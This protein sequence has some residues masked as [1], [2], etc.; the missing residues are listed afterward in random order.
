MARYPGQQPRRWPLVIVGGAVVMLAGLGTGWALSG[1]AS[2]SPTTTSA[3]ACPGG[4]DDAGR[5]A[6]AVCLV[7]SYFALENSSPGERDAK[8]AGLVLPGALDSARTSYKALDAK[9][10]TE[11]AA[12]AAT[13]LTASGTSA[14]SGQAWVAFVDSYRDGSAPLAQW[15]IT[16]F[17][18]RWQGGRW[19]LDGGV[20]TQVDATPQTAGTAPR[21]GFG[22]GW[23]AA[24][25]G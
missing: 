20:A 6:A 1:R 19:W 12:V 13:N 18:L 21:S 8:L 14:A 24:G 4:R 3:V 5:R 23:V 15:W 10:A 16:T 9:V 22:P 11:Y 17:E 2:G 25:A 7:T